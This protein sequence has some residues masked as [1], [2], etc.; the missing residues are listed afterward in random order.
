MTTRESSILQQYRAKLMP[1][2]R[3]PTERAMISPWEIPGGGP[4]TF[5]LWRHQQAIITSALR[6]VAYIHRR[7][8]LCNIVMSGIV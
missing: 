6:N 2:Q 5:N 1:F 7:R 4:G 8:S 3:Q